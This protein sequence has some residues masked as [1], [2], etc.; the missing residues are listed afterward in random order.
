MSSEICPPRQ[1][2]SI[3]TEVN[4]GHRDNAINLINECTQKLPGLSDYAKVLSQTPVDAAAA[5][6]SF[7][8]V[9]AEE[10]VLWSKMMQAAQ[11]KGTDGLCKMTIN[12]GAQSGPHIE[13][14]GPECK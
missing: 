10:Q 6:K 13:L 1:I 2:E 9:A 11:A 3:A 12:I 8:K 7:A 14:D 4:A 5:D